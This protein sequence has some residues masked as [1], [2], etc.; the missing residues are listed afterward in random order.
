MKDVAN[1]GNTTM[2]QNHLDTVPEKRVKKTSMY[3]IEALLKTGNNKRHFTLPGL[4]TR[5][6]DNDCNGNLVNYVS[7]D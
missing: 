4:R 1:V 2:Y 6:C 5:S 3:N 7:G